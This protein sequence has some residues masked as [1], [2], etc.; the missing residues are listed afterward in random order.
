[1]GLTVKDGLRRM[2]S[3]RFLRAFV[4]LSAPS[5]LGSL[6]PTRLS[7]QGRLDQVILRTA[8]EMGS[9]SQSHALRMASA[10][11]NSQS[12]RF[13]TKVSD[14]STMPASPGGSLISFKARLR[15]HVFKSKKRGCLNAN[16][17]L[18]APILSSPKPPFPLAANPQLRGHPRILVPYTVRRHA[19]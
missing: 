14:T 16:W 6:E 13:F 3:A 9:N 15:T 17:F 7:N 8:E 2:C 18:S 5:L 19:S 1:M 4:C 10:E 11:S 12:A